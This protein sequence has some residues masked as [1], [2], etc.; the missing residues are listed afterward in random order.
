MCIIITAPAGN[1]IPEDHLKNGFD[2][3]DDGAGIAI[4]VDGKV[5]V[6]KFLKYEEFIKYYRTVAG[7]IS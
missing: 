5:V 2:G 6:N 3:N 1:A 4:A 7:G